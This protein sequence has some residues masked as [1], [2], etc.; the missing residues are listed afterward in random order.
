MY[1]AIVCPSSAKSSM[2]RASF[3]QE[4][5]TRH[6]S[7][8][9]PRNS[10]SWR[11]SPRA[12]WA[13]CFFTFNSHL[14]SGSLSSMWLRMA[15]RLGCSCW[16]SMIFSNASGLVIPTYVNSVTISLLSNWGILPTYMG[17]SLE[18]ADILFLFWLASS[19]A[20]MSSSSSGSGFSGNG[21]TSNP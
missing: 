17:L 3:N 8:V 5:R 2:V 11:S 19:K 13:S 1:S 14:F 4:R 10:S 9:R 6:S 7:K 16:L 21:A 20:V 18:G 15:R 12:I